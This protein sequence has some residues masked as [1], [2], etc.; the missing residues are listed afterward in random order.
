[1]LRL[2]ESISNKYIIRVLAQEAE[3]IMSKKWKRI[4]NAITEKLALDRK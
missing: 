1:M 3:N 2:V 4:A